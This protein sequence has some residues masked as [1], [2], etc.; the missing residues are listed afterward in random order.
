[1]TRLL[2]EPLL[3]FLLI[4]AGLFVLFAVVGRDDDGPVDT[5]VIAAN[6]IERLQVLFQRTRQRPPSPVELDGLIEAQV[7]ETVLYREAVAMGL[8]KDDTIVRRRMAQKLEFLTQDLAALAEPDDAELAAFLADN[9][10]RFAE[11]AR[12]SF[13]QIYFSTDRRG[14]AAEADAERVRA[15]LLGDPGTAD[16][17]GY[18]DR[19]ALPARHDD[20]SPQQV[21]RLFGRQFAEALFALPAGSWQGPV[22][23]GYGVHLAFVHNSVPGRLPPLAAVR[24]RVRQELLAVRQREANEALYQQLR[25][26]YD[27]V[28]ERPTAQ[29]R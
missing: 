9:A 23:S 12:L 8:D 11:P 13:S 16:T 15:E 26:R 6:D 25:Q 27:I 19:L 24:E 1:M 29:D 22:T 4:G 18:G 3:H 7:R 5:I 2:R 17:A 14:A 28:V 20:L 21:A 10:E